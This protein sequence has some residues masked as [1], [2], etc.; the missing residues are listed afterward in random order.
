MWTISQIAYQ[1]P[2][3]NEE[4]TSASMMVVAF[5]LLCLLL[6]HSLLQLRLTSGAVWRRHI[7]H[8]LESEPATPELVTE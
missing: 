3:S 4:F 1:D 5:L 8:I 7:D 2:L 6:T